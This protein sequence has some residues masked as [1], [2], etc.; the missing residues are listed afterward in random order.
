[1][2]SYIAP[3]EN[4]SKAWL[5]TLEHVVEAGGHA[6]N[7]VSTVAN[8]LA[9]ED[10]PIRS[11]IDHTLTE[12]YRHGIRIQSVD[13]VAGTIFPH[14]LYADT[15]L[16]YR[17]GIDPEDVAKLDASAADLYTAYGE[18]LPILATD[19]ANSRGTYF[20]RM[21]SWP[22]KAAGGVNQIADRITRLRRSFDTNTARRNVEDIA[23]GGEAEFGDDVVGLQTYAADDRRERGF[24]CLVHVDLTLYQR[25]LNMSATYRHQ[26]LVTKAY[27]NLLGLSRLL[28]FLAKHTGF[29]VGEL[30]VVATFADAEQ[31]TYTKRGVAE[32]IAAART[33]L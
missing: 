6:I 21:V 4:I 13:T 8:P 3:A 15:G 7:V 33:G 30:M 20:G 29:E 28:G 9:P 1:M 31:G 12:G 23:V 27:G 2:S 22:G 18:M 26:Y 11:A 10:L 32:L 19:T 25:R 17:V 24:P 5:H 14:D 16:T